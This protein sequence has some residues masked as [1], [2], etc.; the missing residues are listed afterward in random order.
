MVSTGA[1]GQQRQARRSAA[2]TGLPHRHVP[3][4]RVADAASVE[5]ARA[6]AREAAVAWWHANVKACE[7][8]P[9]APPPLPTETTLAALSP[10]VIRTAQD[11]GRDVAHLPIPEAI[12]ALGYLYA[13]ALPQAHRAEYGVYYTPPPLVGRLLD[14]AERAG[15]DWRTGRVIDPSCGGGAFLVEAATRMLAAMN[16]VE[17]SIAIAALTSR[18]R[19]WDVDPFAAW[20]ANLAVE[21]VALPLATAS[22]RRLGTVAERRDALRTFED[23]AGSFDLVIGNPPFGK[24]KDSPLL[25]ARFARSLHGH[26]NLYGLFTDLAVH[27]AKPDGGIVAYLTPASFLAGHYFKALRRL[28]REHAPPVTLD[29]VE[30]RKDVFADVLQEVALST[31]RRGRR[32]DQAECAIV[33]VEPAGLRVE[34]TG[35][36]ILPRDPEAPWTVPRSV[37]DVAF[38]ERMRRMPARL[39]DWGYRVSTGPLVWNRHKPRLHH[40]PGKGRIP[41]VWAEAVTQDGRFVLRATKKNHAAWFEPT[42]PQDPNIVTR[43]CVLVQRTTAKEQHRRLIAAEMPADLLVRYGCVTVENHLN[44]IVPSTVRPPVPIPALAAFLA[45][46]TADRVLRCIN[47]SVAVSA[48]ELEAMPLPATADLLTA[49]AAPDPEAAVARLYGVSG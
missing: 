34:P 7:A 11:F 48:S 31:F 13:Q 17:P 26:P 30:S 46:A 1:F 42:G 5:A 18:L 33:R 4:A 28:L 2:A 27:L 38:V 19:G 36:L 40:T 35:T 23:G 47:A 49:L 12:A 15:H 24:V 25:R 32:T 37:D 21:A 20:L 6:V 44:M 9:L 16:G 14:K 8:D 3:L 29:L 10:E 39:A 41:V 22:G 45:T 43:P